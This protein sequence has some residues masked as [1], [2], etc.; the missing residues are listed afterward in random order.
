MKQRKKAVLLTTAALLAFAFVFTGCDFGLGPGTGSGIYGDFRWESDG[1]NIT[2]TQYHGPGGAVTI[3]AEIN[4][5]QVTSIAHG[6]FNNRQLTSVTIPNSVTYFGQQAFANNQL[7]SVSLPN[8]VTSI[9]IAAFSGNQLTSITIPHSVTY[10]GIAAFLNNLTTSITI[11]ANVTLGNAAFAAGFE[12]AY[13]DGGRLAGTYT[14][15][16]TDSTVWTRQSAPGSGSVPGQQQ[17]P[18]RITVNGL[19][20]FN[21]NEFEI[22]LWDDTG[23]LISFG[24]GEVSNNAATI[25][26]GNSTAWVTGVNAR[27]S[28]YITTGPGPLQYRVFQ[29]TGG[30]DWATLGIT[31]NSTAAEIHAATLVRS[32]SI[33]SH[34]TINFNQFRECFT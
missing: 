13:N 3:P 6:A 9:G 7:T 8:N 30:N 12:I 24:A 18:V 4:R 2:I 10:I 26:M 32:F 28:I 31:A 23:R 29:Y 17:E 1:G 34:T 27:T 19:S 20:N 16:N 14:R 11:G 25:S 5:R 21:G 22:R 15:P 33:A